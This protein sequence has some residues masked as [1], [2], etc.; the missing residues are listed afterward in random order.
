LFSD[1]SAVSDVSNNYSQLVMQQLTS[2]ESLKIWT[3]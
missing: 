3:H 2:N 1:V